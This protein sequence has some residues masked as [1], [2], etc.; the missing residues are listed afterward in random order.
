M[1]KKSIDI[2]APKNDVPVERIAEVLRYDP[3]TGKLFW[4]RDSKRARKG[5]E[6]GCVK[7][8]GYVNICIDYRYHLAHR[9]AWALFH[10][11]WPKHCIDHI[12]GA[13]A[14]NRIQNLR[15]IPKRENAQNVRLSRGKSGL[16]GA[17]WTP[18]A[19]VWRAF[20]KVNGRSKNLG[21]FQSA[22]HAHAAYV[23][24]KRLL[25][26]GCTI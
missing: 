19:N 17:S 11:E 8:S 13:R 26:P 4:L 25:H 7:P 5:A 10:G 22:E 1:M 9:L 20:I 21:D 14:D 15:D 16:L 6:A 18:S 3:E 12:N 24:A 2:K 23:N